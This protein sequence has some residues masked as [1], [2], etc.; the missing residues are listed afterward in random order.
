[1][2]G[3]R[4]WWLAYADGSVWPC[5]VNAILPLDLVEVTPLEPAPDAGDTR[6]EPKRSVYDEAFR[7]PSFAALR[8][9]RG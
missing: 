6:L 8:A 4:R 3:Q 2:A 7:H 5:R 9:E 1:M